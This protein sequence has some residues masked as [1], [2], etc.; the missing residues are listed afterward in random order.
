MGKLDF[1]D[2]NCGI[3]QQPQHDK[4]PIDRDKV[5]KKKAKDVRQNLHT[6]TPALPK[7]KKTP[8][9]KQQVTS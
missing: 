6:T 5:C 1:K 8:Q 9:I 3:A 4:V 7:T 2:R